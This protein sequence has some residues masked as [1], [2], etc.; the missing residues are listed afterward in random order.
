MVIRKLL[1]I[2][3][4]VVDRSAVDAGLRMLDADGDFAD[5]VIAFHGRQL[6][7]DTFVSFNKKSVELVKSEGH[8]ARLL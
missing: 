1:T 6:G 7:G 3:N 2:E 4:V 5:G 8:S